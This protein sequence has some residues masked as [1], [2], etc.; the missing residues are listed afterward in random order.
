MDRDELDRHI[1]VLRAQNP[2][3][4]EFIAAVGAFARTLDPESRELLGRALLAREPETGGFDVLNRR[5]DEGGWF[6][7]TM[8]KVETR[9]RP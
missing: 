8:R 5:L 6:R 9:E 1:D 2:G 7:R 4:D 3:R